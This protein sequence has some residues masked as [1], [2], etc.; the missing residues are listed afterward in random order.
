MFN[1]ILEI[2]LPQRKSAF[3]WGPRQT[4]KSFWLA[5]KFPSQTRFDL[6]DS[7]LFLE[8]SKKPSRFREQVI[9]LLSNKTLVQPVIVDEVQKV[10]ALLDEIQNLI[11]KYGITFILCGSSARKLKRGHANLLGG[12]AWRFTMHPLSCTEIPD[13]NLMHALRNGLIPSLYLENDASRSLGSYVVDYIK[14][15]IAAEGITRNIPAF[16]RFIDSLRFCNGEQ[17]HYTN[18]ARDCGVDAKTVK[19]YFQIL[20]DTLMGTFLPPFYRRAKRNVITETHKFYLFDVGVAGFI[21]KRTIPDESGREFGHA[22]EHFVFMELCAYQSYRNKNFEISYW[23]TPQGHEVDFILGDGE[24]AIEVKSTHRIDSADLKHVRLFEQDYA[25]MRSIVVSNE[26]ME[27]K[28]GSIE[29]IPWKQFMEL[30]WGGKI[31]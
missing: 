4:G 8:Y 15:E 10:P 18:I 24:I 28:V 3:L 11:E 1:R 13:F 27:R 14:E 20:V 21:E 23:R 6:L 12:R 9:S 7:D 30:L 5:N 2:S 19:S 26:K 25:P 31:I 22:F 29:L 16:S 17:V